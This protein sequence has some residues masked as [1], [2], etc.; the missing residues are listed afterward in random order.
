MQKLQR[1]RLG[2]PEVRCSDSALPDRQAA[3]PVAVATLAAS[4]LDLAARILV[5][6]CCT[7]RFV[8]VYGIEHGAGECSFLAAASARFPGLAASH[9]TGIAHA[10]PRTD[11]AGGT[12]DRAATA[13]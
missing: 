13:H 11:C 6:R 4:A 1:L 9:G 2:I 8:D 10:T 12:R 7:S 3:H 5:D